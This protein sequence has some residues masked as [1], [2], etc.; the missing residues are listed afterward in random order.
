MN[1][2][3][4]SKIYKSYAG[5]IRAYC[6]I[7]I[8]LNEW[9]RALS[10]APGVSLQYWKELAVKYGEYLANKDSGDITPY[11]VATQVRRNKKH[12]IEI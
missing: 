5:N 10:V 9:E 11:Y 7:M 8:V 2:N 4:I 12:N 6:D 1:H 3:Y